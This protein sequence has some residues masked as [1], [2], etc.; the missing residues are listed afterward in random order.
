M[1][2]VKDLGIT[3][4]WITI[5]QIGTLLLFQID[6]IVI[7]K[8]FGTVAGGEYSIILMWNTLIRS[9]AGMLAGVLTPVILACY[10]RKKFEELVVISKNA[11]KIMG[12]S[13]ALPIGLICGFSPLILSLWVG[14]EFSRLSP[15]MWLLLSH[16]SINMSVL[17]LFP[18]NVS[19]NKVRIPAIVTIFSGIVNLL[20]AVTLSLKTGCGYYGVAFAG[21]I[22]LTARHFFFVP[23]YATRV[24]GASKIPFKSSMIQVVLSTLTVSGITSIIYHFLNITNVVSLIICC[25]IISLVYLPMIWFGFM[26]QS[27]RRIIESL[28][29]QKFMNILRINVHCD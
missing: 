15:L 24:L 23:M 6:I 4:G 16:L 8:L 17:P 18:I 9:A 3:G 27:E 2:Q 5:D 26:N 14:P 29:P 11:V 28:I 13:M 21:A 10:A 1:S 7:N 25:G 12:L 20:L 22:V 19:Y